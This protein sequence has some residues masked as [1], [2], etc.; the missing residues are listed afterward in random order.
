MITLRTLVCAGLCA[1]L[2]SA[3]QNDK[4]LPGSPVEYFGSVMPITGTEVLDLDSSEAFLPKA[5]AVR[6]SV[7]FVQC[8]GSK[9]VVISVDLRDNTRKVL[10]R[11]GNG[12][13]E[14]LQ[15]SAF[16]PSGDGKITAVESNKRFLI[17]IPALRIFF[18]QK[19]IE[20]VADEHASEIFTTFFEVHRF[21]SHPVDIHQ[22]ETKSFLFLIIQDIS[23]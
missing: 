9:D 2:F 11:K 3:C 6:D 1:S 10:L 5:I 20:F 15:M 14:V 16:S 4:R 19:N 17:E 23:R 18:S 7:V 12:P 13:G 22:S 21:K 8:Q